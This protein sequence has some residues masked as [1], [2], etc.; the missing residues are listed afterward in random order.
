MLYSYSKQQMDSRCQLNESDITLIP[1]IHTIKGINSQRLQRFIYK[2]KHHSTLRSTLYT[3]YNL[4]ST[5]YFSLTNIDKTIVGSL[6]NTPLVFKPQPL[7]CLLLQDLSITIM[8]RRIKLTVSFH[9]NSWYS[10]FFI[11]FFVFL[12]KLCKSRI[13][14]RKFLKHC[15]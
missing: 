5:L 9:S 11:G 13:I 2:R 8:A 7:I 10:L 6:A 1:K 4:L 15:L 14:S 12:N 3:I